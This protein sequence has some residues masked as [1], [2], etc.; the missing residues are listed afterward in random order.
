M[1]LA[2]RSAL[3]AILALLA[4][5]A[6]WAGTAYDYVWSGPTNGGTWD[7]QN[8]NQGLS[9]GPACSYIPIPSATVYIGS[10]NSVTVGNVCAAAGNLTLAA[11]AQL[12]IPGMQPNGV[13]Q[14]WA[15]SSVN[16]AGDIQVGTT[17]S[18]AGSLLTG[19]STGY[20]NFQGATFDGGGTVTLTNGST[21]TVAPYGIDTNHVVLTN[22]TI[23]GDGLISE[24]NLDIQ[25]PSKIDANHNGLTLLMNSQ[26]GNGV[27]T[28]NGVMQASNG[29]ILQLGASHWTG[30]PI[31][32][33]QGA[34]GVIQALDGSTV[35]LGYVVNDPNYNYDVPGSITGGTLATSGS[36]HIDV[37][38]DFL[39]NGVANAGKIN[40]LYGGI[41][42][43]NGVQ[44]ANTINN[45]GTIN[46]IGGGINVV[47]GG[48]ALTG[49]GTVNMGGNA[50]N[51]Y[52]G[53]DPN[54]TLTNVNNLIQGAGSISAIVLNNQ[55]LI[56]S[57]SSGQTLSIVSSTINNAG[58]TLQA[59]NGGM[60]QI[61]GGSPAYVNGG[62]IQALDGSSV[63]LGYTNPGEHGSAGTITGSTLKTAGSG[64][65]QASNYMV[66]DGITNQTNLNVVAV[67][68]VQG[69]VAVLRNTINNTGTITMAGG[70]IQ[71][72]GAAALAGSGTVNLNGGSISQG[73]LTNVNNTIQG[74][75]SFSSFGTLNNAGLI[76]SNQSGGT[77]SVAGAAVTNSGTM[78]ATNGGTLV[79]NGGSYT[80]AAGTVQAG[81]GSTLT[82]QSATIGGTTAFSGPVTAYN[83]T[84]QNLN[85]SGNLVTR[86][87]TAI[88]GT[89]TNAG[90]LDVYNDVTLGY[91]ASAPLTFNGPG[92]TW[93]HG[94]LRAS[95]DSE[96][97]T[98]PAVTNNSTLR[99]SF[100]LDLGYGNFINNG[101]L[102]A[103]SGDTIFVTG[104]YG[105]WGNA[106]STNNGTYR[107]DAGGTMAIGELTNHDGAT[108]TLTGGT[109]SV[110]G[111]L[112]LADDWA[113]ASIVNNAANIIMDGPSAS[114][115]AWF[116]YTG[117]TSDALSGF[118]NNLA[119]G[120]FTLMNGA[121]F[122][123]GGSFS[124][125]GTV[126]IG[127]GST[128][129]VGPTGYLGT[130]TQTAG[131]TKLNGTLI[132]GTVNIAGGTLSGAG[133]LNSGLLVSGTLS[134]GNSPG[135]IIVNGN[136][137]Q[138]GTLEMQ[139]AMDSADLVEVNGN[140]AL[141]GILDINPYGTWSGSVDQDFLILAWTGSKSGNF[142]QIFLPNLAGYNF[143]MDW[144]ANGLYLDV[145]GN[146]P[147]SGTPEP[148]TAAF[149]L[150][151]SIM[152]L[153][154]YKLRRKR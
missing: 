131:S 124:N 66:L 119:A 51:G 16:N 69:N 19:A 103:A 116:K 78:R 4:A 1:G 105:S 49:G 3:I 50:I 21:I 112:K 117:E 111:T 153:G 35:M 96:D 144:E 115:L 79:F 89:F 24:T 149:L 60:L 93:F 94:G 83:S 146:G 154:S 143:S 67:P 23:R 126:N 87:S 48:A 20:S 56:D 142:D 41:S 140:V 132:A 90:Q 110:A 125:A 95:G 82:F 63:L 12:V 98:H 59:S 145:T 147:T 6:G 101:T 120:S 37:R 121:N 28:N 42:T 31:H 38:E 128:F 9:T 85:M 151:G 113:P 52:N 136:Y 86:T 109:Y 81:A 122:T 64:L 5:S 29:G 99:G 100:T 10:G 148:T 7:G 53:N 33:T 8:W 141:G 73:S 123:A 138:T 11:G 71:I 26:N 80:G 32:I 57:N 44:L 2:T 68:G 88:G 43:T 75:G 92:T 34:G 25:G 91:S 72:D 84:L 39:L 76:D 18:G 22:Q 74:A 106:Y 15:T 45:T 77:I 108:R 30:G 54:G 135:T 107:V 65:I 46:L 36:G 17:T 104:G 134:P 62:T 61:G 114:M 14:F 130:Y 150:I 118:N 97:P 129:Q 13:P 137:T 55:S 133:T 27:V 47:S 40:V 102:Y 152:L 127:P 139:V 58:G 70:N